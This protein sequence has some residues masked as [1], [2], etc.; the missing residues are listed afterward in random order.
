MMSGDCPAD[1]SEG[2][3]P[4]SGAGRE[5]GYGYLPGVDFNWK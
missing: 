3:R 1:L 4:R 5:T 2:R